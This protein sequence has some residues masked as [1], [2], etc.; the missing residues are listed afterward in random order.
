MTPGQKLK[1]FRLL[2]GATQK[3]F[4]AVVGANIGRTQSYEKK[5][6]VVKLQRDYVARLLEH[7]RATVPTLSVDWFYTGVDDLPPGFDAP[8]SASGGVFS[9]PTIQEIPGRP[10]ALTGSYAPAESAAK[11]PDGS[12]WAV[13]ADNERAPHL[14]RGDA[15]LVVPES[16]LQP[17]TLYIASGDV[18][19][20]Y[21]A[22]RVGG[23]MT[24]ST[25]FDGQSAPGTA[26]GK[27]CELKRSVGGGVIV[28]R[29]ETG[30]SVEML[31]GF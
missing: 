26:T 17:G 28:F 30:L 13:V 22:K 23:E 10:A 31:G 20:A 8:K 12:Y 7:Y 27:I 5:G 1:R 11:Y 9:Y 18:V 29:C 21:E 16:T 6:A 25:L 24:L 3:E 4:D 14:R 15:V 2:V 19:D